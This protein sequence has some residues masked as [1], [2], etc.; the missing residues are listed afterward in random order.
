MKSMTPKQKAERLHRKVNTFFISCVGEDGYP[1]TKAVVP[2]KHRESLSELY[3]CTNTSSKFAAAVAENSKAHVYF[4]SRK[5]I[6]WQGCSLK[7]DME[8]VMDMK[9]K[10]RLWDNKYKGLMSKE[11]LLTPI[12]AFCGSFPNRDDYTQT[13]RLMILKLN[14]KEESTNEKHNRPNSNPRYWHENGTAPCQH[15]LPDNR[16]AQG[17]EPRRHLHETLLAPRSGQ[18]IVQMCFVLLSTCSTLRRQ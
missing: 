12:F 17:A 14:K 1:L 7:G 9:I 8:I 2:C 15:R 6:V 4:Y 3:F 11:L 10:E 16:I 18:P 5:L 13:S